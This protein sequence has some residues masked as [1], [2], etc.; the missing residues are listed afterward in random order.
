M[1]SRSVWSLNREVR[2]YFKWLMDVARALNLNP[3]ITSA[4]RSTADQARLYSIYRAGKSR[5]PA[6]RPGRSLH[7]HGLALDL[8][9]KDNELLARYW[10]HYVNGAWSPTDSVHFSARNWLS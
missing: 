5:F 7:E 10:K 3:R 6:A 4:R 1:S 2:P 9:S 8:V